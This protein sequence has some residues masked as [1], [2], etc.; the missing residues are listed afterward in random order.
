MNYQEARNYID[1]AWQYAGNMELSGMEYI[2]EKLGNPEK[3]L[4][5]IH[6]AGTNG[7]GSTSAFISSVLEH[8][9]YRVGRYVSP[10]VYSYRERIQINGNCISREELA[11]YVTRLQ[12]YLEAMPE[13]GMAHLT[14]FE[15]ETVIAFMYFRDKAC[16][17]VVLECGMGGRNDATNVIRNTKLAVLTPISLDHVG[18]LG[19]DLLQI[20]KNK[21]GIIKPGAVVVLGQQSQEVEEAIWAISTEN[22]NPLI[23]SKPQEA[24][25]R[26]TGI[27]GQ[28]FRYHG[29]EV[30]IQL[31]GSYQIENAV[32]ALDCVMALRPLGFKITEEDITEGLYETRWD[33]R[34]SLIAR[35][36]F[37]VVD[38]AHNPGA[39]EKLKQSI[40]NCFAGRRLIFIMG[41]FQDK[42]YRQVVSMLAPMA[43]RIFTVTPPD[44]SRAFPA[45]KLAEVVEEFNSAVAP[46]NSFSHAVECAYAAAGP[47][48]VIISFGSLSFIGEITKIVKE[49]KEIE[50]KE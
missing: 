47:E 41:M 46:C 7:K 14:P 49:R 42:D 40:A 43:D 24:V 18:I 10:T 34:F 19:D 2:L 22:G 9:T 39:A 5:F 4:A 15:I 11:D 27:E 13:E 36:P 6:I 20:A 35:D 17:I 44:P 38:G 21:A 3:E 23:V 8:A 26:E 45:E 25:I 29:S 12:P 28:T 30:K 31:A 33:G 32:L 16:D 48:D 50:D 1:Q 37:F